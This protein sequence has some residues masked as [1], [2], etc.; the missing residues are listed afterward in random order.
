MATYPGFPSFSAGPCRPARFRGT[1]GR[2]RA[3]AAPSCSSTCC[4]TAE[5][6]MTVFP[7]DCR[8]LDKRK[9]I[10]SKLS[11]C[12]LHMIA[13]PEHYLCSESDF[14]LRELKARLC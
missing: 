11:R 14:S 5:I 10:R 12:V 13:R 7:T 3:P 6:S 2:S 4:Q 9:R 1:A 8:S